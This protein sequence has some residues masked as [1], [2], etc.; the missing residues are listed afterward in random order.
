MTQADSRLPIESSITEKRSKER[1]LSS[2]QVLFAL[3]L[4][5]GLMLTLNFSSRIQAD[6]EL[7]RIHTQVLQEIEFLEHQQAELTAELQYVKSDAYVEIW[8]RDDG[9]M[10]RENEVLV[11]AQRPQSSAAPPPIAISPVEL[12]TK[13][14]EPENWELWWALFFDSPPLDLN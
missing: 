14:P 2:V 9:K 12:Q 10:V 3:I 7:Q 13:P 6:R 5:V 11:L 8:A 4:T 1:R